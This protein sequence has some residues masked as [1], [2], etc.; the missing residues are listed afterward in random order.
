MMNASTATPM[1]AGTKTAETRSTVRW[2]GARERWASATMFDAGKHGVA[3]DRVGAHQQGAGL[4]EGAADGVVADVLG[5]GH[6]L[7][8]DEDSSTADL[9]SSTSPSTGTFSP[10]RTRSMSPIS[11]WSRVTSSSVPSHRRAA[12]GLGG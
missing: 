3:A 10:G 6:G 12:R 4:V 7:A 11:T 5:D 8:G 1:T 2:M 9:P